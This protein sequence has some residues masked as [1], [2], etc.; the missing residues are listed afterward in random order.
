MDRAKCYC[1]GKAKGASA[2][3]GVEIYFSVFCCG[4]C[5]YKLQVDLARL[6]CVT[7]AHTS[8]RTQ[9]RCELALTKL[10]SKIVLVLTVLGWFQMLR[11]NGRCFFAFSSYVTWRGMQSF[12]LLLPLRSCLGRFNE[13]WRTGC[14]FNAP[15]LCLC[16]LRFESHHSSP[17]DYILV[18][19][20]SLC[21]H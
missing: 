12:N 17:S 1:R 20:L 5:C 3:T 8:N 10:T 2:Y 4:H 9:A 7:L 15:D 13:T 21:T 11:E 19:S 14:L 18:L 6:T 16:C